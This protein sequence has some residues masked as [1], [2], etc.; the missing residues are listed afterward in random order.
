[1]R[2]FKELTDVGTSE[3]RRICSKVTTSGARATMVGCTVAMHATQLTL[4]D[5]ILE[6]RT[7]AQQATAVSYA[8]K[9]SFSQQFR[10]SQDTR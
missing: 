6:S 8:P 2:Q 10:M 5:L 4:S 7:V 3:T 1:M 9:V